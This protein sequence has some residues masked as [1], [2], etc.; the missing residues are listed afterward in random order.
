MLLNI[1]LLAGAG[2]LLKYFERNYTPKNIITYADRSYSQ[3]NLY[4]QIGFKNC[5]QTTPNYNWIKGCF[6]IS[7]YQSQ[8]H[9]LK[10]ILGEKFNNK[11]SE[12]ENMLKNGFLKIYDCGNLIFSK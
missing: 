8:K 5:S 9:K 10:S 6:I 2:K 3:G 1:K 4:R 7:R 12:S 11:L